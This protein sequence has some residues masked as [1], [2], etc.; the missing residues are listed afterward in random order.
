MGDRP[1][2]LRDVHGRR[3]HQGGVFYDHKGNPVNERGEALQIRRLRNM[4]R[5]LTAKLILADCEAAKSPARSC[6]CRM[7]P[8]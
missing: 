4:P 5:L 7:T 3:Y 2:E 1:T 8:R 6:I